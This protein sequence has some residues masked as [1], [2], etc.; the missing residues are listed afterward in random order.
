MSSN[1]T[2][3]PIAK[4]HVEYSS[5]LEQFQSVILGT[6]S[7]SGQPEASY[8][9]AIIDEERNFY[10]YVSDLSAHTENLLSAKK[11]SVLVIEDEKTAGQLF[12]RKR[13]TFQCH[14]EEVERDS[15]AWQS[16]TEKM[17]TELGGVFGHLLG[18]LDFHL[19]RL[20]PESG[21]LVVGFG[22]AFDVTGARMDELEHIRGDGKGHQ[23]GGHT[24]QPAEAVK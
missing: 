21:R 24:R 18:M 11:A 15:D 12:A 23:Q 19:M 13:V 9:P 6:V 22:A 10:V 1:E 8:S 17:K 16:L 4:A 2:N 14:A 5:L 3:D 7:T 20:T